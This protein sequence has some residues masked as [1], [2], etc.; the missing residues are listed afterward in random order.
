MPAAKYGRSAL[1]P[2]HARR[3]ARKI[4]MVMKTDLLYRDPNLSLWGLANRIGVT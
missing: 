1:T 4:K 2:D 3:I